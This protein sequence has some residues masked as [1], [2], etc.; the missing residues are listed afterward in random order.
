[1]KKDEFAVIRQELDLS[2][3]ELANFLLVSIRAIQSYEQ[4]W[5]LIPP[6]IERNLLLLLMYHRH[7]IKK[8]RIAYCHILKNCSEEQK[9][10]C[11]A[12]REFSHNLCWYLSGTHCEGDDTIAWAKK[13]EK[14]RQCEVFLFLFKKQH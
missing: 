14:C 4:G 3:K 8:Q 6:D 5:R 7:G 10:H 12:F 1:M 9:K 2:Q 11:P 13:I